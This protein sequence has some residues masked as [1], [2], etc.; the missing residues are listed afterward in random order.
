[1]ALRSV[2]ST[3]FATKRHFVGAHSRWLGTAVSKLVTIMRQSACL[4][5]VQALP[6]FVALFYENSKIAL[7]Q[8][9]KCGQSDASTRMCS[10]KRVRQHVERLPALVRRN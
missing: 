9:G 7:L 2:N 3:F 5:P 6:G 10:E 1:M 4:T 8:T